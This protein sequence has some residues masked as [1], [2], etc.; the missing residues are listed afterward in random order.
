MPNFCPNQAKFNGIGIK[1]QM[2]SVF[3]IEIGD[4]FEVVVVG[5]KPKLSSKAKS[6]CENK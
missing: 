4:R 5:L 2:N 1:N 6:F 3:R